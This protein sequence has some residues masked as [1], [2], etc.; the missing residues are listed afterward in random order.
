MYPVLNVD[1][2]QEK[3]VHHTFTNLNVLVD[4]NNGRVSFDFE[5][6]EHIFES[7]GTI[8]VH[9]IPHPRHTNQHDRNAILEIVSYC[10][11]DLDL[12]HIHVESI[13]DAFGTKTEIAPND[14]HAQQQIF[15]PGTKHVTL[16]VA[17]MKRQLIFFGVIIRV[18]RGGQPRHYLCDPQVGN[19]PVGTG[20][21]MPFALQ[22][23]I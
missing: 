9:I 1:I 14:E 12:N 13:E 8:K 16:R 20:G 11:T 5:D 18:T 2:G 10:T 7:G 17:P 4:K 23:E 19:G 22:L 3:K 21:F 15:P 6:N